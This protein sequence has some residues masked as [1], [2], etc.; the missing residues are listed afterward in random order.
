MFQ[1]DAL[2]EDDVLVEGDEFA[3]HVR[4]QPVGKDRVRRAVAFEDAVGH[5]PIRAC[6]PPLTSSAVLPK[7]SASALGEHVRHQDV[8]VPAERVERLSKRD[9]VTR[10][11]PRALMDQLVEGVLAVGSRFTPIDWARSRRRPW[12]P[13]SVT[14]LP[15]LSIVNCCR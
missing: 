6:P 2:R 14:C 1:I 7:A 3:E 5:E 12:S 9:E 11:E 4:R 13:S 15:L 10:D 8:V